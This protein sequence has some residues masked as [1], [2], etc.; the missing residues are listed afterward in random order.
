MIAGKK[1]NVSEQVD[2][3]QVLTILEAEKSYLRQEFGV[4][5]L[6]LF[7]SFAQAKADKNSDIDL[8]VQLSWPLGFKFNH[9]AVYLENK[10]GRKVD[11]VTFGSLE[12]GALNPRHAHIAEDVTRTLIYV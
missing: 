6:A 3:E 4:E 1:L 11:L 2:R 8:L 7:G 5:R 10:L 12:R 9:L